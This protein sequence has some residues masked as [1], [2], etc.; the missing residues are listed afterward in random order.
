L[1]GHLLFV[2]ELDVNNAAAD[3]NGLM[4]SIGE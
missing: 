3:I 2:I 4:A 1:R